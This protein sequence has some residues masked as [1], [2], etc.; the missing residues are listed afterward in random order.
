MVYICEVQVTVGPETVELHAFRRILAICT[1]C[2]KKLCKSALTLLSC[3]VM[4]S[5]AQFRCEFKEI[6]QMYQMYVCN[7]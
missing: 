3:N 1:N 5:K 7:W 6:T 2:K 4:T